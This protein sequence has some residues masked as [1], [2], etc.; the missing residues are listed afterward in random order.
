MNVQDAVGQ[1]V[2]GDSVLDQVD[3]NRERLFV[4]SGVEQIGDFLHNWKQE[5]RLEFDGSCPVV[6]WNDQCSVKLEIGLLCM[7]S[8]A[9][10]VL[11]FRLDILMTN[12]SPEDK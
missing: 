12:L 10:L 2:G 5:N 4:Q 3:A 6:I 11:L 1:R 8:M 7:A 9:S